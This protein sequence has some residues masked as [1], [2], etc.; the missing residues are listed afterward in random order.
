MNSVEFVDLLLSNICIYIVC[1]LLSIL[2]HF[3]ILRRFIRGI[4]D[5]L[6]ITV[7]ST[8]FANSIPL[9]LFLCDVI[10]LEYL[11]YVL[12]VESCLWGGFISRAQKQISYSSYVLEDEK[13]ISRHVFYISLTLFVLLKFLSYSL[14]GIPL[15]M[16]SRLDAN[17]GGTGIFDRLVQF[18]QFYCAI[19]AFYLYQGKGKIVSI[20]VFLLIIATCI[21]SGSKGAILELIYAYFIYNF[22]YLHT[23]VKIKIRYL[24]ALFTGVFLV[25][26]LQNEHTFLSALGS[27]LFRF[28]AYGDVYWMALPNSV[29]EDVHVNHIFNHLF[30]GFLGPLRLVSYENMEPAIGLQLEWILYPQY[31]GITMGPNARMPILSLIYFGWWGF[32]FAFFMGRIGANLMFRISR[33]FPNSLLSIVFLGYLYIVSQTIYTDVNYFISKLFDVFLVIPI[34]YIILLLINGRYLKMYCN[35]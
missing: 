27:I 29:I 19:Y 3:S 4:I 20:L 8:A 15:F 22:F 16:V 30:A 31:E 24:I 17:S 11:L 12:I 34:Y 35:E 14:V 21:L 7:L 9:F 33:F 18:P 1:L 25:V 5:P 32:V 10:K 26:I 28:V 23:T 2:V 6:F 13:K